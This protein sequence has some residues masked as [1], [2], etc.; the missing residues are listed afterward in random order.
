MREYGKG[1]SRGEY[2]A[3]TAR[4]LAAPQLFR[5][6][7]LVYFHLLLGGGASFERTEG[8]LGGK[9]DRRAGERFTYGPQ[10]GL[11]ADLYLGNR[12]SLTGSVTKA[13]LFNHPLLEEWPGYV[14][15]GVR[16]HYR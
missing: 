13:R 3:Y 14:S 7:E 12:F 16:Y 9:M 2:E 6:G 1:E 4:L 15:V 11:E 5:I 8:G 10:A